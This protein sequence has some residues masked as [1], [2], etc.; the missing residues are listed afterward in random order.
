SFIS[1]TPAAL[2]SNIPG[3]VSAEIVGDGADFGFVNIES[4]GSFTYYV[5]PNFSGSDYFQYVVYD[6]NGNS[7]GTFTARVDV[8]P[9]SVDDNIGVMADSSVTVLPG[10]LANDSH[11]DMA[12]IVPGSGPTH[13][14]ISNW[15]AGSFT[16]TPDDGFVGD[17]SFQY[18][19]F[20]SNV[21]GS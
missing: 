12:G 15:V 5:N 21:P 3:A 6:A 14:T 20:A 2:L 13:G 19:A 18:L 1:S 11:A 7:L 10:V 8:G 16:Y 9:H 17:D 4:D